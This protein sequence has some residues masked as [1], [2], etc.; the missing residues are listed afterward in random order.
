MDL[1]NTIGNKSRQQNSYRVIGSFVFVRLHNSD[2]EMCV[3]LSIWEDWAKQYCWHLNANG[4]AATRYKGNNTIFHDIAFQER[5]KGQIIDHI[6]GNRLDN[7]MA[8]LRVV[9][10]QQNAFNTGMRSDNTSGHIGVS[11]SK[12]KSK[13]VAQ[14]QINGKSIYLG[15]YSLIEDA[16]AAREAA[17]VKYFGEYRRKK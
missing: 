3:D 6:N 5:Y 10:R 1:R 2:K 9:N 8:N 4:Y 14:I 12:A 17:E 11:W 13:W 15:R 16:I 7:R